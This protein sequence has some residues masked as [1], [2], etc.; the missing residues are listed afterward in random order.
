ML[1]Q[2]RP[3]ATASGAVPDI[4]GVSAYQLGPAALEGDAVESSRA[5]VTGAGEWTVALV[6]TTSGIGAFNRLAASCYPSSDDC[7][8]GQIALVLDGRAQSAPSVQA[9]QFERDQI[10]I[11]GNF[12]EREAK[13][14]AAVLASGALPVPLTRD[15]G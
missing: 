7:P 9:S 12:S 10:T 15:R 14:L 5:E 8:T 3:G 2:V 4:D 11:S 13:D 1:A 6:L